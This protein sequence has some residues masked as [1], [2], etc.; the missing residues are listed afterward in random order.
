MYIYSLEQK[1][2]YIMEVCFNNFEKTST[3]SLYFKLMDKLQMILFWTIL[4]KLYAG[5]ASSF[6]CPSLIMLARNV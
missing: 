6:E 1:D 5:S 2:L 4:T 3:P